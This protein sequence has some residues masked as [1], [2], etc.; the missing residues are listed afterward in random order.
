MFERFMHGLSPSETSTVLDVGVTSDRTQ[1]HSNYFAH[2]YPYKSRVTA[3]GLEN[4]SFLET[5]YPGMRFVAGS[6]L[7]LPFET[8]EFDF[9][10]SA[11][12]I[13]HVG[14]FANQTRM[15][16]ELWRVA[17]YGVFATTPNRW[18]PVEVHTVLPLIHYLPAGGFRW[19]LRRLGRP[20]FADENNLNLLSR[21]ALGKAAKL[22]GIEE[23]AIEPM[24]LCGFT[25]NLVLIAKRT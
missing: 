18:F 9:V 20:F 22:A 23:F 13:E 16:S 15:L 19:C 14:S 8:G 5:L 21:R 6:A 24:R 11:A 17:R 12:V 7:E 2:W 1:D 3:L 4:A 25:S 10:H